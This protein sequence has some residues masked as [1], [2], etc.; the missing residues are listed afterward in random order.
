MTKTIETNIEINS[1]QETV[2]QAL[3][4]FSEYKRWNFGTWFS[5][6]PVLG[7]WQIMHV[8]LFGVWVVVPVKIL[9]YNSREGVRWKG[10]IPFIF[11]GSHY[12]KTEKISDDKTLYIQGEDF[13]GIAVPLLL[14]VMKK[15]LFT[16]YHGGNNNI[17]DYCESQ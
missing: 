1:K 17:K 5:K 9:C 4:R 16:L 8:K 10:G 15:T 11:M 12:F 6:E 14:P 3:S 7:K 2:W 13:N